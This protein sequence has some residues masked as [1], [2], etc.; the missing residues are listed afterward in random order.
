[1]NG[2]VESSGGIEMGAE[3]GRLVFG[4]QGVSVVIE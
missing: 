2:K 3:L 1:M 4:N